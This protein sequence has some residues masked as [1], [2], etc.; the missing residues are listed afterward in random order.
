MVIPDYFEDLRSCPSGNDD[1]ISLLLNQLTQLL[2]LWSVHSL[3]AAAL[4][5][6]HT[7]N[8]NYT[9]GSPHVQVVTNPQGSP[10]VQVVTNPQGDWDW[11]GC[12]LGL[13][14]VSL[15]PEKRSSSDKSH[16]PQRVKLWPPL[17]PSPHGIAM[18]YVP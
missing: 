1:N 6:S 14:E 9:L 11:R 5:P 4:L 2:K 18:D 13:G 10:H 7:T 15:G 8:N 12:M 3:S 16:Q 17:L